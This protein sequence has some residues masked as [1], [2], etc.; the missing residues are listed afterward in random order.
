MSDLLTIKKID[1][2]I[3]KSIIITYDRTKDRL[4]L[5]TKTAKSRL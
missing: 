4:Y 5:W 1:N 2:Q 3:I